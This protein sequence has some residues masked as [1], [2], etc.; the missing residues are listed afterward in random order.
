MWIG[1]LC[2]VCNILYVIISASRLLSTSISL[3]PAVRCCRRRRRRRRRRTLFFFFLYIRIQSSE[4]CASILD[5]A[6]RMPFSP[7]TIPCTHPPMTLKQCLSSIVLHN[8]P[9]NYRSLRR[10]FLCPDLLVVVTAARG[11]P[12]EESK[13]AKRTIKRKD[14]QVL[15]Q[16]HYYY[17]RSLGDSDRTK[18]RDSTK[19]QKSH[20]HHLAALSPSRCWE[21]AEICPL[22][23]IHSEPPG[24]HLVGSIDVSI[25]PIFALRPGRAWWRK[26]GSGGGCPHQAPRGISLDTFDKNP[27]R[28]NP[29]NRTNEGWELSSTTLFSTP[30]ATVLGCRCQSRR[31]AG[32]RQP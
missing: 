15:W 31:S 28:N 30:H 7:L 6:A 10:F 11:C 12:A 20:R 26:R 21:A 8:D 19:E 13:A 18:P 32:G 23:V 25:I 5:A 24:Y 2:N 14:T 17:C 22:R 3:F 4:H 1:S 27:S 29:Q 9:C 16:G